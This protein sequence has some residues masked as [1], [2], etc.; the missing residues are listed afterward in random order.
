MRDGMTYRERRIAKFWEKVEKSAGCWFYRG[1]KTAGGYGVYEFCGR[2]ERAHRVAYEVV[3]GPI[4][5]GLQ[6]DHLCRVPA[7]V[8]P[9]HLEP[10]TSRENTMRG[11]GPTAL[12]SRRT[13]CRRGHPLSGTNLARSRR[14]GWRECRRCLRIRARRRAVKTQATTPDDAA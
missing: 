3:V 7:C 4:P 5:D 14:E 8:N 9:S 6:L 1:G 12:A 2:K 11:A 13:R 10:V